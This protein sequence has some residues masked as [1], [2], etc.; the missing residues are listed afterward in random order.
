MLFAY[1]AGS[2]F[3]FIELFE[4]SPVSY[5]LVM[6]GN[7]CGLFIASHIN[8]RMLAKYSARTVLTGAVLIGSL[9]GLAVFICTQAE[10][11]EIWGLLIP[12]FVSLT[13]VGFI[14]PNA[15]AIAMSDAG[16]YPGAGA[17]L[18]GV[19][20]FSFAAMASV[21][22]GTF[23]NGT[24]LPMTGIIA[25]VAAAGFLLHL[26]AMRRRPARF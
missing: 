5:S 1:S 11:G 24:S 17:A 12:L 2:A 16:D 25:A 22:V 8:G 18:I 14:N 10:W 20:Q 19:I 6:A 7:S 13:C 4:L 9:S 3:V 21:A 26:V 23:A 15:T